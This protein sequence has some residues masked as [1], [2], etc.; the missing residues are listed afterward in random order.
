MEQAQADI[1]GHSRSELAENCITADATAIERLKVET[2]L[3]FRAGARDRTD[4]HGRSC[5]ALLGICVLLVACANVAGLLLSR[6]RARSREIAVRLAIGAGRGALVRQLLLE[7]L[8]VAVAGGVGGVYVADA[9]ADVLRS[10]P[11]PSD[12]PVVFRYRSGPPGAAVHPGGL[13]VEH[14]AVR[15]G[16]RAARH[17]SRP[18]SG[19]ESR[20]RRQRRPAPPMGPQHH[21]GGPG[22]SLAGACWRSRPSWCRAF[23]INCCRGRATAPTISSSPASTRNWR[24]TRE[25]RRARFYK[26]LL[27]ARRAPRRACRSAALV[28]CV[29]MAGAG[30]PSAWF[31]KAGS[32]RAANR[33]LTTFG[34][35][36]SDGYFQNH[37]YPHS[38]RARLPRIGSARTRRW[39]RW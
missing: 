33:R 22:G 20:R 39:W 36:V 6:A 18:G 4:R 3:Q 17:P 26:D 24:T 34:A 7:N 19:F 25:T 28:S 37:G 9:V 23:A 8:L 13:G 14:A 38:A 16:A 27:D 35:Y 29:P 1:G 2:E 32:C 15:S 11:I 21:R 31:R 30:Q 5:S 10:I 12:L